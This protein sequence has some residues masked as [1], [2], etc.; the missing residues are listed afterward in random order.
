[1]RSNASVSS[2]A[3][4]TTLS[5]ASWWM[6]PNGLRCWSSERRSGVM[7]LK[8]G[9][10]T[11]NVKEEFDPRRVKRRGGV[12]R[13]FPFVEVMLARTYLRLAVHLHRNVAVICSAIPELTTSTGSPAVRDVGASEAARSAEPCC[14]G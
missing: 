13:R 14:Y 10:M 12:A 8:L 7:T 2:E 5:W 4:R 9:V 6:L 3:V 11:S 1:M